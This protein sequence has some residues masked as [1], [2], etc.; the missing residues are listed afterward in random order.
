MQYYTTILCHIVYVLQTTCWLQTKLQCLSIPNHTLAFAPELDN[1]ICLLPSVVACLL[2]KLQKEWTVFSGRVEFHYKGALGEEGIFPI[3]PTG[4]SVYHA[5]NNLHS[6][7]EPIYTK[8]RHHQLNITLEAALNRLIVYKESSKLL[9]SHLVHAW[10]TWSMPDLHPWSSH[11]VRWGM[12]N[13]R[14]ASSNK[15]NTV[16]ALM[17]VLHFENTTERKKASMAPWMTILHRTSL[18]D[19]LDAYD[20]N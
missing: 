9:D 17:F 15:A 7:K 10:Y 13:L 20:N 2:I 18:C 19:H 6:L 1:N 11:L 14:V 5:C 16:S 4:N 3:S 8:Q 12:W